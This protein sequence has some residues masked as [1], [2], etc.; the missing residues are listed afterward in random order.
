MSLDFKYA[1]PDVLNYAES[2]LN[3]IG[4][5]T[6]ISVVTPATGSAAINLGDYFIINIPRC[7]SDSVLDAQGSYLRFR[8]KNL[9]AAADAILSES[10]D[11]LFSRIEVCHNNQVIELIDNYDLLSSLLLDTQVSAI[12][13][14]QCLSITKGCHATAGTMTGQTVTHGAANG[15]YYTTTLLSGVVGSL[16][17]TYIPLF[18][19][20]GNLSIRITT[21]AAAKALA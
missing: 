16:A 18:A 1:L 20:A 12:D 10:C 3:D 2:K 19:L 13:R 8:L 9:A 5:Y 7:G 21:N 4:S 14:A 11:C 17:R 15:K 6:E